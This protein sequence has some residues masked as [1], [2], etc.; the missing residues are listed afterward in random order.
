MREIWSAKDIIHAVDHMHTEVVGQGLVRYMMP[1]RNI[2]AA[3]LTKIPQILVLCQDEG[4]P[5]FAA[6]SF[7]M[8]KLSMMIVC[9]KSFQ[10]S[11][12]SSGKCRNTG[13]PVLLICVNKETDASNLGFSHGGLVQHISGSKSK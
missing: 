2:D 4:S 13:F 3:P 6:K 9:L 7:L 1:D 10:Y 5:G 8:Y 12:V 11:C